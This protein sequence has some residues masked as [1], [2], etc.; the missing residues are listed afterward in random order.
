MATYQVPRYATIHTEASGSHF[1]TL[2]PPGRVEPLGWFGAASSAILRPALVLVC[3][4]INSLTNLVAA[5]SPIVVVAIGRDIRI[6][7]VAG[8]FEGLVH[9]NILNR[10]RVIQN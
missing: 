10:T 7:V 9:G 1:S 5:R 6:M 3:S 2:L 8:E 4:T